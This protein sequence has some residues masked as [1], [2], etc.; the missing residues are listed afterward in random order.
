ELRNNVRTIL[1]GITALVCVIIL[2]QLILVTFNANPDNGLVGGVNDLS[3]IF[4]GPF[5]NIVPVSADTDIAIPLDL[6]IAFL[7]ILVLGVL[8]TALITSVLYE[9]FQD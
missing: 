6:V 9:N 7:L 4:T 2:L 1:L 3:H 8:S 5:E